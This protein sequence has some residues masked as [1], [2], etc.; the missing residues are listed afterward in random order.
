MLVVDV[1]AGNAAVKHEG[2]DRWLHALGDD[3]VADQVVNA[4]GSSS[5]RIPSSLLPC[6]RQIS[7]RSC[8]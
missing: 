4:V 2:M 6:E 7:S 8:S 5:C 3:H 1:G